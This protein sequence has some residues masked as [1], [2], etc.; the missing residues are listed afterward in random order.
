MRG[1]TPKET[2]LLAAGLFLGCGSSGLPSIT[3][4]VKI[5]ARATRS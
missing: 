3:P 2:A 5:D 4:S 1:L